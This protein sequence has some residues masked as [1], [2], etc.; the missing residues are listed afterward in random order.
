[1]SLLFDRALTEYFQSKGYLMTRDV[2]NANDLQDRSVEL[3]AELREAR[4]PGYPDPDEWGGF[5][6]ADDAWHRAGV[7]RDCTVVVDAYPTSNGNSRLRRFRGRCLGPAHNGFRDSMVLDLSDPNDPLA[8]PKLHVVQMMSVRRV[9][10]WHP[11][12]DPGVA[13]VDA[14][15]ELDRPGRG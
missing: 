14:D 5:V 1:M 11:P 9:A 15:F 6:E 7:W 2:A 10:S 3:T 13:G 12:T 4:D 8:A